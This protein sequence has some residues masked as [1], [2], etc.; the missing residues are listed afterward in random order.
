MLL[1]GRRLPA[2]E[3]QRPSTLAGPRSSSIARKLIT[4]AEILRRQRPLSGWRCRSGG[5]PP[6][7]VAAVT[8]DPI[9]L[10]RRKPGLFPAGVWVPAPSH[11]RS[12]RGG[13]MSSNPLSSTS[14]SA[15]NRAVEAVNRAAGHC[16]ATEGPATILALNLLDRR[17][18]TAL[19]TRLIPSL[20]SYSRAS[21]CRCHS[22]VPPRRTATSLRPVASSS[23][24]A[25][26]DRR[27]VLQTT[28]IGC[29]RATSSPAWPGRSASGTLT[30]PGR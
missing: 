4:T 15:T 25:R 5:D 6:Y 8:A 27:S 9:P 14:E 16:Q 22:S 2:T 26:A 17:D 11:F 18:L 23:V 12:V 13:T 10:L 20:L 21:P 3:K 28:T 7:A 24:A 1:H 29:R 30:A 19:R